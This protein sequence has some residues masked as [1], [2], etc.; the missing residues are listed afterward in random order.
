MDAM[1]YSAFRSHLASTLD[2]VNDDHKPVLIVYRLQEPLAGILHETDRIEFLDRLHDLIGDKPAEGE[3]PDEHQHVCD[4]ERYAPRDMEFLVAK[5]DQWGDEER[6]QCG[7]GRYGQDVPDQI[8]ADDRE[9]EAGDDDK[10]FGVL[11]PVRRQRVE[12]L[13]FVA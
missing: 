10:E 3:R 6:Y 12:P 13:S 8:N 11:S 9:K 5:P 1:S 4:E 7:E 2:K